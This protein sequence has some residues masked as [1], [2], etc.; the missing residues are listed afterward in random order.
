MSVSDCII[1]HPKLFNWGDNLVILCC[2]RLNYVV[3]VVITKGEQSYCMNC[4]V[5]FVISCNCSFLLWT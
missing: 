5:F 2:S 1:T 4:S 3:V